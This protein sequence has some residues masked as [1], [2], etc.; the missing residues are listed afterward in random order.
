MLLYDCR[1]RREKQAA[2]PLV[3]VNC[4]DKF[5]NSL[6]DDGAPGLAQCVLNQP[7]QQQQQ[8]HQAQSEGPCQNLYVSP[9]EMAGTG[10][11]KEEAYLAPVKEHR[12]RPLPKCPEDDMKPVDGY[13]PM[14]AASRRGSADTLEIVLSDEDENALDGAG[15]S[16]DTPKA[17]H[18]YSEIPCED[19][20]YEALDDVKH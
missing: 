10:A 15:F 4:S 18:I 11:I 6:Y 7:R 1:R 9:E 16:Y 3:I 12:Q 13:L 14:D 2:T 20:V 5:N 8:Q 19:N 17:S